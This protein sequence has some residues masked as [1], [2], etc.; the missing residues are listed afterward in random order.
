MEDKKFRDIMQESK[1]EIQFPD[2]DEKVMEQIKIK[3]E[4]QKSVW[5]SLKIS[6]VFFILG[7]FLGI[8]ASGYLANI[9]YSFTEEYNNWIILAVE[10]LVV[11]IVVTQ[12]DKL[13]QF[14]F[15]KK[16]N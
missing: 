2:F 13:I 8:I 4:T 9:K 15:R 5:K 7:A 10:I 16:R 14:T 11:V 6:W 3:E 12:F 1:L